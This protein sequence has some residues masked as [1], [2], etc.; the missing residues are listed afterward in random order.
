MMVTATATTQPGYLVFSLDTELAWGYYDL[1]ASRAR[2]FSADGSRERRAIT[3]L[4]DLCDAH[5]IRATWALVGHLFFDRCEDCQPCP[6]A[7]WQRS[8]R[9]FSEV[10]TPA[11]PAPALWY[12]PDVRDQL[13]G[14]G[15]RH[16]IAFHGF[17]HRPFPHMDGDAARREIDAW[18][19]LGAR[20]GIRPRSIVFPRNRVAHLDAFAAAGF[21][22]FRSPDRSPRWHLRR[23][24]PAVKCTDDLLDLSRLE[25][26]T[27]DA[28]R[29][30]HGLLRIPASAYLFDFPRTLEQALDARGLPQLR[31]RRIV[32]AIEHAAAHGGVVHLWAHP[33]E[34]RTEADRDKLQQLLG[35]AADHIQRGQLRSITMDELTTLAL[36]RHNP[37]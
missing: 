18:L 8:H 16:E 7:A 9:G 14:A 30:E 35:I 15:D 25:V 27:L 22:C 24:G 19:T 17:T 11:R 34:L 3:W 6:V 4:L 29:P 1:D 23:F 26:F 20:F 37:A 5:G 33:W 12:A 28:L 36:E 13:L 21:R 10:Y 31:F 32:R 2:L